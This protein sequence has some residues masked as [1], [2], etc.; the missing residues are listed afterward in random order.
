MAYRA[1][2]VAFLFA[3]FSSYGVELKE[4]D[5]GVLL[6][7]QSRYI[8]NVT[9]EPNLEKIFSKSWLLSLIHI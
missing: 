8:I 4:K 7:I 5:L 3:A 1:V 9:G 2:V 6:P